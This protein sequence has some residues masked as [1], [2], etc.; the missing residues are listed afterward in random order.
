MKDYVVNNGNGKA[1]LLH[2]LLKSAGDDYL[3]VIRTLRIETGMSLIE[4]KSYV[5]G[6]PWED[7]IREEL[8]IQLLS[9]G[10]VIEAIE[11]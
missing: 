5:D 2:V 1:K 8:L 9:D 11:D 3:E 4:A 6:F 7:W 10:A